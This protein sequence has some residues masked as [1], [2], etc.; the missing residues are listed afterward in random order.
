M[1]TTVQRFLHGNFRVTQYKTSNDSGAALSFDEMV[2]MLA[3]TATTTL[4]YAGSVDTKLKWTIDAVFMR[5]TEHHPY[6][7]EYIMNIDDV[8]MSKIKS[9][10]EWFLGKNSGKKAGPYAMTLHIVNGKWRIRAKFTRDD[11]AA[12]Y[13]TFEYKTA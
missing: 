13:K 6:A 7:R 8:E 9:L 3:A 4:S 2:R 1:A 5:L 12:E 11:K 10:H